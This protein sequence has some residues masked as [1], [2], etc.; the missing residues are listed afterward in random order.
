MDHEILYK[1]VGEIMERLDETLSLN[2]PRTAGADAYRSLA[3]LRGDLRQERQERRAI[4][5]KKSEA[6]EVDYE[7]E[8]VALGGIVEFQGNRIRSLEVENKQLRKT[9]DFLLGQGA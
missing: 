8:C 9:L 5:V 3:A 7:A 4:Q 2:K 1:R 6:P